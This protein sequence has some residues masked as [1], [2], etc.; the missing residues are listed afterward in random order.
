MD[1]QERYLS[2]YF[3]FLGIDRIHFIR[4]EGASKSADIRQHEIERALN[5]VSD[6]VAAVN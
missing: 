5:A 2:A 1:F 3:G 6:I 4:V